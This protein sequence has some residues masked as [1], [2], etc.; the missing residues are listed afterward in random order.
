MD[1]AIAFYAGNPFACQF[2]QSEWVASAR[3]EQG[4]VEVEIAPMLF[5]QTANE[6]AIAELAFALTTKKTRRIIC[7]ASEYSLGDYKVQGPG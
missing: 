2:D 6:C 5:E 1:I 4:N 3:P 7:R